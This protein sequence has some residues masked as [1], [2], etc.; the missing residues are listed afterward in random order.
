[1]RDSTKM[2][3]TEIRILRPRVTV[4]AVITSCFAIAFCNIDASFAEDKRGDFPGGRRGG[5]THVT[6][7]NFLTTLE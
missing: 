6:T 7:D 2:L 4:A 1:M 3:W 5:G